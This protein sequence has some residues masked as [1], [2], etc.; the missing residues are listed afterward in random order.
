VSAI[1]ATVEAQRG[2]GTL[3][4]ASNGYS[5]TKDRRASPTPG[6]SVSAT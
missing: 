2:N 1:V 5:E 4:A 3:R 6:V